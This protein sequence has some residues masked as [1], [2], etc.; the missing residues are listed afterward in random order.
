M[1]VRRSDIRPCVDAA[2]PL[3]LGSM[4]FTRRRIV[5]EIGAAFY[6]P[7]IAESAVWLLSLSGRWFTAQATSR[8]RSLVLDDAT[9]DSVGGNVRL[10]DVGS[11][12]DRARHRVH[13]YGRSR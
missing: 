8:G 7:A 1:R 6:G 2:V 5:P 11:E 12:R 10:S 9:E 3:P 4:T 13:F